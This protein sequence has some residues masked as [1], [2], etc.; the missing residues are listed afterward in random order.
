MS[1]S[2]YPI[3]IQLLPPDD[4]HADLESLPYDAIVDERN[5]LYNKS[6]HEL[7]NFDDFDLGRL[8]RCL[9]LMRRKGGSSGPPATAKKPSAKRVAATLPNDLSDIP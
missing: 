9:A 6:K 1:E 8:T 5:R 7:K 2:T 3:E 4:P